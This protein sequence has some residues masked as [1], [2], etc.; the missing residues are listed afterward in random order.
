MVEEPGAEDAMARQ[1]ELNQKLLECEAV[2][3][4]L[5]G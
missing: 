5:N 1:Q 3:T 4:P 2:P